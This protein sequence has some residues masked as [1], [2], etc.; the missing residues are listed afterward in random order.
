MP[1]QA[2][3]GQPNPHAPKELSQFAFLIGKWRAQGKA[4]DGEGTWGE[5]SMRWTVRYIL[6]GHAICGVYQDR[7]EGGEWTTKFVDFRFFDRDTG[8][9]I[10]E[11]LDPVAATLRVQGQDEAGGVRVSD[12]SVTVVSTFGPYLVRETFV[13]IDEDHF[14]YRSEGSRDQ[15]ESWIV[16]EETQLSRIEDRGRKRT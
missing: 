13:S 5:F 3:Y 8:S 1:P 11:Y 10:V 15:G 2:T 9:W 16:S 4:L 6:D 7:D 12:G 14:T